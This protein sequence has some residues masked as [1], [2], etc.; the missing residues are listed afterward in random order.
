MAIT[1]LTVL[2]NLADG[3]DEDDFIKWRNAKH[4]QYV[5]SMPD[6]IRTDFARISNSWPEGIAPKFRFQ[7]TVDWPNQKSFEKAFFNDAAQE[8]LK[9]DNDRLGDSLFIVSE[10]LSQ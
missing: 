10:I 8:K 2:Y 6:V 7:T 4:Q 3:M 9:N 1:R 5:E